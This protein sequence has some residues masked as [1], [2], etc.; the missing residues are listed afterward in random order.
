MITNNYKNKKDIFVIVIMRLKSFKPIHQ[1]NPSMCFPTSL[2]LIID[3]LRDAHQSKYLQ[4]GIHTISKLSGYD[5]GVI[6]TDTAINSI[7]SKF[8]NKHGYILIEKNG[9]DASMDLI[10]AILGDGNLSAPIVTFNHLYLEDIYRQRSGGYGV[11]NV[12]EPYLHQLVV[13]DLYEDEEA[14]GIFDPLAY[15]V[16]NPPIERK[17]AISDVMRYWSNKDANKAVLYIER[18]KKD[19]SLIEAQRRL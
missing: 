17:I 16:A 15:H 5:N 8:L 2:K 6:D 19:P 3:S 4:L 14:V 13:L 7:N 18:N 11:Y 12:P 9:A 10:R 1:A